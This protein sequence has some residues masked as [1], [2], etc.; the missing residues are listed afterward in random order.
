MT[1]KEYIELCEDYERLVDYINYSYDYGTADWNEWKELNEEAHSLF[2]QI[3][4][5]K[6]EGLK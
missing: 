3:K 1:R 4:E 2:L 6:K 5:A